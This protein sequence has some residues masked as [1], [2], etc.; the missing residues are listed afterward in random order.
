MDAAKAGV[1]KVK[2]TIQGK[3]A[4]NKAHKANDPTEKPSER[5]DAAFESG[6]ARMKEQEHACK[7]ECRK[8]KHVYQ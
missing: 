1:E 2:E 5:A 3:K 4:E 6:K 8:D 7:A